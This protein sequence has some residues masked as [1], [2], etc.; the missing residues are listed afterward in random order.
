MNSGSDIQPVNNYDT[1]ITAPIGAIHTRAFR[2]LYEPYNADR[3]AR[4]DGISIISSG[5]N[6]SCKLEGY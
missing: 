2:Y 1:K 6:I 5:Y 3:V 4:S